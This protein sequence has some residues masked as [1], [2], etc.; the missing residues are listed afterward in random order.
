MS[1]PYFIDTGVIQGSSMVHFAK[2]AASLNAVPARL[3]IM[4]SPRGA[5]GR[6]PQEIQKSVL[7][8]VAMMAEGLEVMGVIGGE[9][10]NAW[11]QQKLE[12]FPEIEE[13]AKK[14]TLRILMGTDSDGSRQAACV[15]VQ[16]AP[17]TT[18]TS[19]DTAEPP[20]PSKL[21]KLLGHM[22]FFAG[23]IT[24]WVIWQKLPETYSMAA[25]VGIVVLVLILAS[26][27]ATVASESPF[28]RNR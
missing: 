12:G 11:K 14:R 22:V 28:H 6:S 25:R 9:G 19:A 4:E 10:K 26:I 2:F 13:A 24:C 18:P 16:A 23:I 15:I 8:Q 7:E 27:V 17:I 5:W 21:R 20:S 1:N 3:M